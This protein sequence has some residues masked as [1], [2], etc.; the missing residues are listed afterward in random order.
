MPPTTQEDGDR[1]LPEAQI[2]VKYTEKGNEKLLDLVYLLIGFAA[3]ILVVMIAI[4]CVIR[5]RRQIDRP[6]K[7][8]DENEESI[9]LHEME[10]NSG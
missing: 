9:S 5:R 10:A 2:A 6:A 8:E 7:S 1:Q 3:L 4:I